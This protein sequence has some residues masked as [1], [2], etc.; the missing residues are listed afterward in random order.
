MQLNNVGDY[1][2]LIIFTLRN[3]SSPQARDQADWPSPF[4][5]W[6]ND[7]Q[8]QSMS[9]N[10]I[11][12]QIARFYGYYSGVS[13]APAAAQL[14]RGVFPLLQQIAVFDKADNFMPPSQWLATDA[15]TKLQIRGASFGASAGTLEVLTRNVRPNNGTAL[16]S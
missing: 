8:T 6:I 14:D 1:I 13:L 9:L 3:N 2:E 12:R 15:T 5:F 10:F 7:F 11:Q 4:T 16:F